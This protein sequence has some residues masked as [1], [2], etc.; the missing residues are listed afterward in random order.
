MAFV[1]F[2]TLA[3]MVLEVAG[4]AYASEMAPVKL[5]GTYLALFGVCFG[6]AHGFSPIVA[7]SLLEA[8]LPSIIWA[9]QIVAASLAAALLVFMRLARKP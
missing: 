7:G 5:R 2:F 6:A 4:A 8:G 1:G 3:E 9:I